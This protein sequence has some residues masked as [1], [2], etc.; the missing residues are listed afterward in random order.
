MP[1]PSQLPLVQWGLVI[2]HVVTLGAIIV[3]VW[4]T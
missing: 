1:D 2:G 3:Y 4:K